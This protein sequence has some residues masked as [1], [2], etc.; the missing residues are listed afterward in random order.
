MPFSG[1]K[2]WAVISTSPLTIRNGTPAHVDDHWT[3]FV[4]RPDCT[5]FFIE[6]IITVGTYR[7]YCGV[8]LSFNV[9][10]SIGE[11]RAIFTDTPLQIGIGKPRDRSR[12]ACTVCKC[13]RP[14]VLAQEKQI[15]YRIPLA[16]S[17]SSRFSHAD[18]YT[19]IIAIT[20]S[21]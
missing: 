10:K 5:R 11:V 13:Y 21:P 14:T 6:N 12:E 18:V 4:M 3:S 2:R 19:I 17:L 16:C 7:M 8:D 9:E 1:Y 20:N 15:A